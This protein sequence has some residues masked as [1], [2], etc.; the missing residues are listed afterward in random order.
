MICVFLLELPVFS[1]YHSI[2]DIKTLHTNL[3]LFQ[4]AGVC[5]LLK[6]SYFPQQLAMQADDILTLLLCL[7]E[8][9][10]F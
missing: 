2:H 7:K 3:G 1:F 9:Y 8:I 6:V 5:V 10:M 4:G